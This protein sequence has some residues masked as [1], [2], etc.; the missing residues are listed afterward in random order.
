MV[1]PNT[2][3][4]EWPIAGSESTRNTLRNTIL[5][6]R[7][8]RPALFGK[9]TA[10][11]WLPGLCCRFLCRCSFECSNLYCSQFLNTL[12]R[13]LPGNEVATVRRTLW[14]CLWRTGW[15]HSQRQNIPL[16]CTE[17]PHTGSWWR[18]LT[19]PS[20]SGS[21]KTLLLWSEGEN[22]QT[23]N[24]KKGLEGHKSNFHEQALWCNCAT[25]QDDQMVGQMSISQERNWKILNSFFQSS[26]NYCR[27]E[28]KCILTLEVRK[29]GF[30][31]KAG[32]LLKDTYLSINPSFK[33]GS[34]NINIDRSP[35]II[36]PSES[37]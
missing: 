34:S 14:Q 30:I 15:W 29:F 21:G 2:G 37:Y 32:M 10:L 35:R 23:K 22:K 9:R 1:F 7:H 18:I 6:D 25:A 16:V 17:L 4:F 20:S 13:K 3:V 5:A 12:D 36:C 28:A 26:I 19:S 33:A 8:F 27:L 24:F 31:R 11:T